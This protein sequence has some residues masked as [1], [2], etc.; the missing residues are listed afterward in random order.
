ML[1]YQEFLSKL[2]NLKI[3]LADCDGVLTDGGLYYAADGTELRKFHVLDGMGF[4]RLQQAG[5]KTGIITGDKTNIVDYR[6]K[7]LN[8][9]YYYKGSLDKFSIICQIAKDAGIDISQIAYMA[10][11]YFDIEALKAVGVSCAPS[12]ADEKVK[13]V[14]DYVTQKGGGTGCFREFAEIILNA[15]KERDNESGSICNN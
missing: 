8:V 1:D 2:R 5:Y 14:V 13:S 12:S 15:M 9:D 11:D 10:D 7:K 3:V 4:I 6:A